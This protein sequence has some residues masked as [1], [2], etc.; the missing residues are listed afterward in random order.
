MPKI[1]RMQTG[2]LQNLIGKPVTI[3][4]L[5]LNL[6]KHYGV[7]QQLVTV[8]CKCSRHRTTQDTKNGHSLKCHSWEG[9]KGR[10]RSKV[11]VIV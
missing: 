5:D 10:A 8:D 3:V 2:V 6:Q 11:N 9:L 4:I 1:L 7:L